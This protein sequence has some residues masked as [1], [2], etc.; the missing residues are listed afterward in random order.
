MKPELYLQ[1]YKYPQDITGLKFN[2]WTVIENAGKNKSNLSIWKCRCECGT[3]S[4][5]T[6]KNLTMGK[7][8]ACIHKCAS[9]SLKDRL[10]K[11]IDITNFCWNWS[12][13]KDELGYGR[14]HYKNNI[15]RRPYIGTHRASWIVFNGDIPDGLLVLH[16]CDNPSCINP[17][18]LFLGTN[19]DNC[20]DKMKKGRHKY[21]IKK[22]EKCLTI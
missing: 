19:R 9:D 6:R 22:D 10:L 11:N 3:E 7:S 18:H 17:D 13:C 16:K 12:G 15:G 2:K 4:I 8:R 21:S 1:R 20:N 14:I 5:V